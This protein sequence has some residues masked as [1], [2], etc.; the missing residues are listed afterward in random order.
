LGIP[1]S[2]SVTEALGT[3][4]LAD[5]QPPQSVPAMAGSSHS[6]SVGGI[7]DWFIYLPP[8]AFNLFA[9]FAVELGNKSLAR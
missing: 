8:F 5:A 7:P 3:T 2:V 1:F 9:V 4:F 6:A